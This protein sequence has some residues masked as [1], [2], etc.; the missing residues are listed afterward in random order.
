MMSLE[1]CQPLQSEPHSTVRILVILTFHLTSAFDA[2][3]LDTA[4]QMHTA[5]F[6]RAE[7]RHLFF[8]AFCGYV[9]VC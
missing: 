8:C 4:I 9:H 1:K 7:I 2:L 5:I 6:K 3:T